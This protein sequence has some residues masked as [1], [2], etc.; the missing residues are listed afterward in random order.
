M[1]TDRAIQTRM[2][3]LAEE[4]IAL[5]DAMRQGQ[6]SDAAERQILSSQRSVVH[7][8]L[9]ALIGLTDRPAMDAFAARCWRAS[10]SAIRRIIELTPRH[11]C[12]MRI[13]T[14]PQGICA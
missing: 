12:N 5:V 4:Y 3:T 11:A 14:F 10:P 8:Q 7:D 9:I 13:R 6:Y 2:R 1:E